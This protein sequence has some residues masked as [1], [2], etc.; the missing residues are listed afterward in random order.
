IAFLSEST[1]IERGYRQMLIS[2]DI[3]EPPARIEVAAGYLAEAKAR[4]QVPAFIE[5]LKRAAA[6][7]PLIGKS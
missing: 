4:P 1:E 6:E 2:H 3:T 7:S 5:E